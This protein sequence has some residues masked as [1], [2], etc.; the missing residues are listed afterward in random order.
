[1]P[2]QPEG[3]VGDPSPPHAGG[4]R[5]FPRIDAAVLARTLAPPRRH[6]LP[7]AR[8]LAFEE[9]GDLESAQVG[10]WFHGSPS[11]RLEGLLLDDF[12]SRHGFR[13]VVP[14]RPG[15]GGSDPAPGWTMRSFAADVVALADGL[16]IERFFVAG[17]SG[18]GPFTLA[19]AASAPARVSRAVALACAGAFD[20]EDLRSTIGWVDRL[21]AWAAGRPRLLRAYFSLLAA[22][23]R[24]P[25][26]P[27]AAVGR[28]LAPG[29]DPAFVRLLLRTLRASSASGPEGWVEDTRVLH[30]PWG[31]PLEGIEVPVVLVHG[32]RDEFVPFAYGQALAARIPTARLIPAEGDDHFRTIF[33]LDRL[34]SLL[35]LPAG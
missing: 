9:V 31:I 3:D 11:G 30:A 10:F 19:L 35:A 20:L 26:G 32:T 22:L 7:D 17:G 2:P 27:A 21:A 29:R 14:D 33:D 13:L 34:G 6:R 28:W 16:G 1:M 25:E 18:G 8:W 15:H 24:V 12:G 23:V 5:A 4:P